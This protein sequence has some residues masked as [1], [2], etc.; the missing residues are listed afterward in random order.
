[1][2]VCVCVQ[3][4]ALLAISMGNSL[5]V[6]ERRYTTNNP[7]LCESGIYYKTYEIKQVNNQTVRHEVKCAALPLKVK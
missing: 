3:M 1:M 6:N 4:N 5:T 2:W 7:F